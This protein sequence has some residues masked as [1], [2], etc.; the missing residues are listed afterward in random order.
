[1]KRWPS[2]SN[3][4]G[5]QNN[6]VDKSEPQ[7]VEPGET[8][9]PKHHQLTGD[10]GIQGRKCSDPNGVCKVNGEVAADEKSEQNQ[11]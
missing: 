8:T 9:A 5:L 2:G 1:M 10:Q 11:Q 3:F 7:I 6:G 4:E